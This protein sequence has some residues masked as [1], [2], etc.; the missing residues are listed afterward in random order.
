MGTLVPSWD[1]VDT[2]VHPTPESTLDAEAARLELARRFFRYLGP[3]TV[4]D[5]QWWLD[6]LRSDATATVEGLAGELIAVALDGVEH[7][8]LAEALTAGGDPGPDAEL[9]LLL[10]PDDVYINR[11]NGS[12]LVPDPARRKLLWPQ[13]PPPGALVVGGEVRGTWRRRHRS[14][15][16]SPWDEI[17]PQHRLQAETIAAEWPLG[18]DAE[19]DISWIA[20]P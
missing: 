14:V 10:P 6:G 20:V 13:A 3:A 17:T 1:T 8:A 2:I 18:N 15:V 12:L 16:I 4:K 7:L 9:V 5:L 19:T 11:L